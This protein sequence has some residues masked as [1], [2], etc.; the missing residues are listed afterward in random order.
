MAALTATLWRLLLGSALVV[1][2]LLVV[3]DPDT[4]RSLVAWGRG[5]DPPAP[6]EDPDL[7]GGPSWER[8]DSDGRARALGGLMFL[9]GVMLLL[10]VEF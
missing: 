6:G 1:A 9:L 3:R 8:P 7:Q 5:D 2:G 10:G 4:A